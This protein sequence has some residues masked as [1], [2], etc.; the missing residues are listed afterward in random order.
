MVRIFL[1]VNIMLLFA[2]QA[3]LFA[4]TEEQPPAPYGNFIPDNPDFKPVR[5]AFKSF[6][7]L[8][9]IQETE[10]LM[11]Q[12][13]NPENAELAAYLLGDLYLTMAER[14]RPLLFK[15][16]VNA[17]RN[18]RIRYPDS[19]SA[20]PTLMKMGMVYTKSALYYEALA[21]YDRIIKNHPKSP[22][23]I[24]AR[25][26]RGDVY[27]KWGKLDKAIQAFDDIDP[28]ILSEEDRVGLLLKYAE[29]YFLMD[30]LET[31]YEYYKLISLQNVIIQSSPNDLYQYG[32][33]A[34]RSQSFKIAREALFILNNKYP[35]GSHS[36]LAMARIGDSYRLEGQ[37]ERAKKAYAE[38]YAARKNKA[39]YNVSNLVASVG[40]LHLEGCNKT[41]CV[42]M[43]ALKT[44]NG[45]SA[46]KKIKETSLFLLKK[47][48]SAFT[49][50]LVMEAALALEEHAIYEDAHTLLSLMKPK[51]VKTDFQKAIAD[52]LHRTTLLSV[53]RLLD[54]E[55]FT[56]AIKLYYGHQDAFTKDILAGEMGLK[57]SIGFART[58]LY[59]AST[60]LLLSITNDVKNV[61]QQKA[62]LQLAQNSFHQN[63]YAEAKKQIK[64][65]RTLYSK[66]PEWSSLEL[67]LAEMAYQE[68]KTVQ[69]IK[70]Y[71]RWLIRYP[72]HQKRTEI[73]IRLA[74]AYVKSKNYSQAVI[75]Y[76]KAVSEEKSP[77]SGLSIKIADAYF[78]LKNYKNSLPYYK[79]AIQEGGTA[80]QIDWATF[81]LAQ[82]YEK[83]GLKEKGVPFYE[84]LEKNAAEGLIQALSR[85]KTL[86]PAF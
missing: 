71:S 45:R 59:Q 74:D 67:L 51:R 43:Q 55:A 4:F 75:I 72:G 78:R 63:E 85:Q 14:N 11:R 41:Q 83:L 24:P 66:G 5:E 15:N 1:I 8:K 77:I 12:R 16:A 29:V 32:V 18:A 25:I 53:N 49:E 31:A 48:R 62:L 30:Q 36:L 57:L 50:S 69:A 2:F 40:I 38:V 20:L 73:L 82:S 21:S 23:V 6:N 19:E 79:K 9:A 81:Q 60:H 39:G 3:R 52:A 46:L 22:Y 33:T 84:G 56:E 17:Y 76:E 61:H 47:Q 10:Q 37:L 34:Y 44:E 54:K 7:F 27:L 64:K 26:F 80:E 28:V 86:E 35:R 58:G 70:A 65:Y 13:N 42:P 68:G